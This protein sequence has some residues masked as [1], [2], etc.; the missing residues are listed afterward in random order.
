[1]LVICLEG[2][3]GAGKS[4]LL[5]QF[6]QHGFPILDE[7]FLNIPNATLHPQSLTMEVAWVS[8]WFQRLLRMK[9]NSNVSNKVFIADRSPF[10]AELYASN[11]H[12]LS[13]MLKSMVEELEH[14]AG[15]K[16]VTVY[17]KVDPNILWSRIQSRLAREPSR[18][19]Y[20]EHKYSWMQT[21]LEFYGSRQWDYVV[22]NNNDLRQCLLE[23]KDVLQDNSNYF[24]SKSLGTEYVNSIFASV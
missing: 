17:L 20:N 8:A 7:A 11:G 21:V 14:N 5:H 9:E 3:H 23:V 6:E 1:M 22:S 10:S 19:L 16:I 13:S 18:Q 4:S 12:L 24:S 15:I 2:P